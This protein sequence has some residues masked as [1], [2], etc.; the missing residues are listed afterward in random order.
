MEQE[1]KAINQYTTLRNWEE[2]NKETKVHIQ[3]GMFLYTGNSL[4]SIDNFITYRWFVF[5]RNINVNKNIPL[6]DKAYFENSNYNIEEIQLF[7]DNFIYSYNDSTAQQTKD[8][9]LLTIPTPTV[10]EYFTLSCVEGTLLYQ[11]ICDNFFREFIKVFYVYDMT[12]HYEELATLFLQIQQNQEYKKLFCEAIFSYVQYSNHNDKKLLPIMNECGPNYKENFN[13]FSQFLSIQDQL[14]NNLINSQSTDNRELNAYKLLSIQ[15]AIFSD[16]QRKKFN[17]TA[18]NSYIRYI[19]E[20]LK[21][22][23]IDPFYMDVIYLYNNNYLEKNIIKNFFNL[24]GENTDSVKKV[25][26]WLRTLNKWN[27]LLGYEGLNKQ[28]HNQAVLREKNTIKIVDNSNQESSLEYFNRIYGFDWFTID[29]TN[30]LS[31]N[32]IQLQWNIRYKDDE[33]QTIPKKIE[34]T[35]VIEEQDGNFI[36]TNFGTQDKQIEQFIRQTISNNRYSIPEIHATIKE[37]QV[38]IYQ[39]LNP[40]DICS[41]LEWSTNAGKFVEECSDTTILIKAKHPREWQTIYYTIN[42]TE[43]FIN[44]ITTDDQ[45]VKKAIDKNIDFSSI[46]SATINNFVADLATYTTQDPNQRTIDL[47]WAV[48]DKIIIETTIQQYLQTKTTNILEKDGS[49]LAEININDLNILV[50]YDITNNTIWPLILRGESNYLF[51][52]FSILL[53]EDNIDQIDEFLSNPQSYLQAL[54]PGIYAR[55]E[56]AQPK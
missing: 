8:K 13:A 11:W 17:A 51:E 21:K 44:T 29:Q 19:E 7:M 30:E 18:V 39:G 48:N 42:H 4:I 23:Q 32:K 40:I 27:N 53:E 5:P 46:N 38:I 1:A 52:S 26:E 41:K 3:Q 10:K 28:V 49:F 56:N 22:E 35:I 43:G 36:V 14:K 2:Q 55:Y 16:L 34:A 9:Q 24:Q 33:I 6:Q 31:D 54:E 15:Q 12:Q 20:L 50:G 45:E 25:L 47:W 37:N